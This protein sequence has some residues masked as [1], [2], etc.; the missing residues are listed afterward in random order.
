[1]QNA[2][3]VEILP[4]VKESTLR[5]GHSV[6]TRI[7]PVQSE[8]RGEA[9]WSREGVALCAA[10]PNSSTTPMKLAIA[11]R[12]LNCIVCAFFLRFPGFL[13]VFSFLP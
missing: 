9:E 12:T 6:N 1:M 13:T 4:E 10:K 11:R 5:H 3:I 8:S 7:T 2:S